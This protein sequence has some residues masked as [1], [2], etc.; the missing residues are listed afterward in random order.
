MTR[1]VDASAIRALLFNEN[2]APWVQDETFG[3]LLIA[4]V[5][6]PFELG[7]LCW[8]KLRRFPAE[9]EALRRN[10]TKW[11]ISPPVSLTDVEL[12][13]TMQLG[14]AHNLTFYDASYL[15]LAQDRGADLVSLDAPLV[16]AARSLGLHAPTPDDTG[17]VTPSSRN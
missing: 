14:H 12:G 13:G 9:A 1:V 17:H 5:L 10:W 2:A 3:E 11:N 7:N 16:R 4:P 8:K 15:W 6:F